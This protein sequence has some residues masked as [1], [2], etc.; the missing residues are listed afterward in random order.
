[1]EKLR[2]ACLNFHGQTHKIEIIIGIIRFDVYIHHIGH[3][4]RMG[5]DYR[6]EN[7]WDFLCSKVRRLIFR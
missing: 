1:M 4:H 6:L 2:K 7:R 5:I 3:H